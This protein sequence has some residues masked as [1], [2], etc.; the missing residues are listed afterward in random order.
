MNLNTLGMNPMCSMCAISY[1]L[2]TAHNCLVAIQHKIAELE[3]SHRN[4]L[5]KFQTA[6]DSAFQERDG[7]IQELQT[8]IKVLQKENLALSKAIKTNQM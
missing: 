5:E 4:E 7:L 6:V 1:K 3:S 2:G 8:M